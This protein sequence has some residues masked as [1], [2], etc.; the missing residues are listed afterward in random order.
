[1]QFTPAD[2]KFMGEVVSVKSDASGSLSRLFSD[3]G[4]FDA[5]LDDARLFRAMLDLKGCLAISLRFYFYVLVRHALMREDVKDREVA[6]YVAEVLSQFA[7][8]QRWRHVQGEAR[9]LD[10]VSDMLETL[11]GMDGE[12]RFEMLAHVG[13]FSLFLS[14]FFPRHVIR[15]MERRAAPGFRFYEELGRA[16]FRMAGDHQLARKLDLDAM[17]LTL[18]EVFHLIR[19]GLNQLSERLVF[20][21]T[22]HAV[23]ELFR[24]IDG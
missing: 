20:L 5:V 10:Y 15:R 21:E 16:H 14:G 22:N 19:L 3:P 2:F 9:P 7:S 11:E 6:D 12:A 1:M 8:Q 18:G 24:E 4:S 23:Q 13:N 17:Y